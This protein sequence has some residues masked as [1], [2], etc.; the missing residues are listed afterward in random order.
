MSLRVLEMAQWHLSKFNLSFCESLQRALWALSNLTL[1]F[2]KLVSPLLRI[3]NDSTSLVFEQQTDEVLP[4]CCETNAGSYNFILPI[5]STAALYQCRQ[6]TQPPS[7]S[8]HHARSSVQLQDNRNSW[9]RR[10]LDLIW[11]NMCTNP[12]FRLRE[13]IEDAD[14][15]RIAFA[16]GRVHVVKNDERD[17]VVYK[18]GMWGRISGENVCTVQRKLV[19]VASLALHWERW[20]CLIRVHKTRCTWPY[21][22]DVPKCKMIGDALAI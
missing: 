7:W 4:S 1:D 22:K 3:T 8:D 13:N 17:G 11:C 12:G 5:S 15:A 2:P 21:H 19:T 10:P 6:T 18:S 9:H 16:L 20:C 14:P